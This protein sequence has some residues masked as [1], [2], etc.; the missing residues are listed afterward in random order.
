MK[1]LSVSLKTLRRKGKIEIKAYH[2]WYVTGGLIILAGILH[3]IF[4]SWQANKLGYT[5]QG[6]FI[7]MFG[8]LEL[9]NAIFLEQDEKI[10]LRI[11]RLE[12]RD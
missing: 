5:N 9:M 8:C 3:M 10:R 2:V 7:L 1:S 11:E 4:T 12:S 6:L